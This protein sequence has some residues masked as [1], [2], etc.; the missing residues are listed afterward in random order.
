MMK[1]ARQGYASRTANADKLVCITPR[2]HRASLNVLLLS[3]DSAVDITRENSH[4]AVSRTRVA[5]P[6]CSADTLRDALFGYV[7]GAVQP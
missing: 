7:F 5:I 3:A 6:S 4:R 1:Y 2:D